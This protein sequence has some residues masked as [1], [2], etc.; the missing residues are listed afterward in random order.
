[1]KLYL[2]TTLAGDYWTIADHPTEAQSKVEKYLNEAD[3]GFSNN[4]K[5]INIKIMAEAA[6]DVRFITNKFLVL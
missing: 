4:R 6:S 1:M 5:A 2:V 3:Y